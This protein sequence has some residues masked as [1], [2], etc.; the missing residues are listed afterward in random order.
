MQDGKSLSLDLVSH[1]DLSLSIISLDPPP[2]PLD[3]V[4]PGL[5]RIELR[6]PAYMMD[7]EEI[8]RVRLSGE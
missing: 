7:D 6:L 2:H 3:R 8:V 1:P 4:I 5:K